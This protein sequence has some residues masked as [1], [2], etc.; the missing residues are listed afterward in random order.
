MSNGQDN[1]RI[2]QFC[3]RFCTV[4]QQPIDNGFLSSEELRKVRQQRPTIQTLYRIQPAKP[5]GFRS[6]LRDLHCINQLI[7]LL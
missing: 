1:E 7:D 5:Y 3:E 6:A 2:R 4:R